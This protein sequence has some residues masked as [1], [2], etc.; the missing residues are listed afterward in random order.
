MA[1]LNDF[2]LQYYM[3]L[4]FNKMPAEVRAQFDKYAKAGDF[5]GNMKMWNEKLVSPSYF[6][7]TIDHL[8]DPNDP[9]GEWFLENDEWDKLFNAIQNALRSMAAAKS[10]FKDEKKANEFLNEYFG[11]D[12]L[13]SL[14]KVSSTVESYVADLYYVLTDPQ[15]SGELSSL[16]SNEFESRAEY[17]DFVKNLGDKKYNSDP[18]FRNKLVRIASLLNRELIQGSFAHSPRITAALSNIN[19]NG[20][21]SGFDDN[22]EVLPAKREYFKR[23]YGTILKKLH[24][25]SKV[26]NVFKVHDNGKISKHLDEAVSKVAYGDKESKDYVPP[27]ADDTLTPYQQ[28]KKWVGDTYENHLD[29]YVKLSGDRLFFSDQAQSIV[30][31][32]DGAKIKSTDGLDKVLEKAGDIKKNLQYKSA[33]ASDHFDWFE[34]TLNNIKTLKPKAFASALKNARQMRAIVDE[35]I[36]RAVDAGKLAEAK[37]ALEI[38]SVIRY[39]YTTSKIMDALGKEQLSIFSDKGLSWNKNEGMQFVTNALDK[40]IKAAFMITGYSITITGNAIKLS[41]KKYGS[42]KKVSSAI[43]AKQKENEQQRTILE[44]EKQQTEAQRNQAQGNLDELDQQ[45]GINADTHQQYI[46]HMTLR[47]RLATN[48]EQLNQIN[49]EYPTL[50]SD[51]LQ[52]E[53]L[54]QSGQLQYRETLQQYLSLKN[55]R[56]QLQQSVQNT[57]SQFDQQIAANPQLQN[58]QLGDIISKYDAGIQTIKFF[59]DQIAEKQSKIDSW[60][61]NHKNAYNELMAYWN[62]LESGRGT[63]TGKMYSWFGSKEAS[64]KKFAQQRDAIIQNYTDSFSRAA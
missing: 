18:K 3:Q 43:A 5:R 35:I 60:D 42:S 7:T 61:S 40:S 51:V 41:G 13:F 26:Y 63:H 58:N 48:I 27:K 23:N 17:N 4:H 50:D 44:N 57:Q 49:A 38:I 29:K 1:K 37:T 2:L 6:D 19:L 34:K 55:K 54:I 53:Q 32:I 64:Q 56:D 33:K 30:S 22:G 59:E 28:I 8:P 16:L 25:D 62:M 21:A 36:I 47:D 52:L 45:Y 24:D 14:F 31:A 9:A 15:Y 46:D 20:I 11:D 12:K 10:S 39:G